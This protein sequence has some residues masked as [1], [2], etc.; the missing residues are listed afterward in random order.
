M[1]STTRRRSGRKRSIRQRGF[2][3]GL[4]HEQWQALPII[5]R[6]EL[7]KRAQCEL[8]G[9][10]RY[11]GSKPCRRARRC[12]SADPAACMQRLRKAYGQRNKCLPKT[13]RS[14]YARLEAA[15]RR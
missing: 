8:F 6:H 10:F 2:P 9:S 3:G 4:T 1:V 7:A 15:I 5:E 11:C 14:A 13:L 12:S